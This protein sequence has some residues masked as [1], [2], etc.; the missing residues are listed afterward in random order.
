ML[1]STRLPLLIITLLVGVLLSAGKIQQDHT[2]ETVSKPLPKSDTA[3]ITKATKVTTTTAYKVEKIASQLGRP[4]AVITLPDGR[5]LLTEKSGFMTL[6]SSDGALLK[7]ITNLP[8]V[9]KGGQGGLLDVAIDPAFT[10]NKVIYWSYSEKQ[11]AGGNL[12]A[13]A[14]GKLSADESALE[15][16]TVIFRATPALDSR[17]HF[18][19]RLQFD[20]AGHLFVSV[21]ERSI[22]EGRR[23]AQLL[24]SG[25]GKIFK[26]TTNG[27]PAPGNPFA[28]QPDVQPGIYSYGHRNPQGLDIHPVTG[29]LWENEF[30]PKGG[31]EVNRVLPGKNYGWPV[32]TYGLEYSGTK[33]GGGIQAMAGMEQPVYYWNPVVSPAEWYFIQEMPYQSGRTIFLLP[34]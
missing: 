11:E 33:V 13:V 34:A 10:Q 25:L 21:G 17:S 28:G 26:I 2:P 32:I 16:I 9:E 6:H 5:L 1:S 27:K 15:Q 20:K 22:L 29:E 23:Q 18:G 4:W 14:K 24:N 7:K 30:G 12:T 3:G 8:A 19:S 31:D